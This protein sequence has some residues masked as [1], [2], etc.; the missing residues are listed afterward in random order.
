[1]QLKRAWK[2]SS[3]GTWTVSHKA[4]HAASSEK[5]VRSNNDLSNFGSFFM[6]SSSAMFHV[7]QIK[8]KRSDHP[9]ETNRVES[10][11]SAGDG[12]PILWF[13]GLPTERGRSA[14]PPGSAQNGL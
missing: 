4:V 14:V 1:M 11:P 7:G 13:I 6:S 12:P 8:C 9:S 3:L 10:L 2:S 5:S